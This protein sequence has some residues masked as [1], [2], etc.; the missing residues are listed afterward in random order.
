LYELVIHDVEPFELFLKLFAFLGLLRG[1]SS[2]GGKVRQCS[3]FTAFAFY[4]INNSHGAANRQNLLRTTLH[5]EFSHGTLG[6]SG[7]D[8]L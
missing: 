4:R 3:T 2:A 8:E 5:D 6:E 7:A 1:A